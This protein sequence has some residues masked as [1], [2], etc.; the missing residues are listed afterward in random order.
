MTFFVPG[1][2]MMNAI[3]PRRNALDAE[4][5]LLYRITFG[6]GLSMVLAILVS[7]GLN[8]LGTNTATGLGY[9]DAPYLWAALVSVSLAFF[10]IG[11]FRGAYPWMRRMHP[12]LG[13]VPKP[14]PRSFHPPQANPEAT[15]KIEEL[16]TKRQRL[17]KDVEAYERKIQ[18]HVGEKRQRFVAKKTGALEEIEKLDRELS[19]LTGG[20]WLEG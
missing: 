4:M 8:A 7:F 6:I 10:G 18:M 5:D 20:E 1:Y 3:F 14:D 16:S 19:R 15:F 13:R 11:W 17:S 12:K 2:L 9:L